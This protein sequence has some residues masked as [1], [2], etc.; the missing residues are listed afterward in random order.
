MTVPA[1][2]GPPAAME[3]AE[4]TAG[5]T[6]I[7]AVIAAGVNTIVWSTLPSF[8]TLSKGRFPSVAVFEAKTR[9]EGYIRA[10]QAE[11]VVKGVFIS[12]KYFFDNF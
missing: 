3:Q 12:P 4:Y 6:L 10:K 1:P 5:I 8:R 9:A 11:G 2:P 7:D